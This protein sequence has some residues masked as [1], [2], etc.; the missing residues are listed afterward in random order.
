MAKLSWNKFVSK[1]G[2]GYCIRTG[3]PN[4][5]SPAGFTPSGKKWP[6]PAALL[7][8]YIAKSMKSDWAQ[9]SVKHPFMRPSSKGKPVKVILTSY[10]FIFAGVEDYKKVAVFLGAAGDLAPCDEA[11]CKNR[12]FGP[13]LEDNYKI[14]ATALG[15]FAKKPKS[16]I[17]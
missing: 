3:A 8:E 5:R 10:D 2:H 12:N 7:A 11:P 16:S 4:F 17:S 14:M 9:T 13:K 1:Y 15:Y 6:K